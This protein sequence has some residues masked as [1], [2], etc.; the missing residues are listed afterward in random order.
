MKKDL[1]FT[2]AMLVIG[3]GG[4]SMV[5]EREKEP[6]A[7]EFVSKGYDAFALEYSTKLSGAVYYPYQLLLQ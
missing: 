6:I 7:L 1:I 2:P 3:G 5:S 4:Y